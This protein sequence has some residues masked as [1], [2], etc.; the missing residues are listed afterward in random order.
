MPAVKR[1]KRHRRRTFLREWRNYRKMTLEQVAA[2]IGYDHSNLVRLETGKIPYNQDH[3]ELLAGVYRCEPTDLISRDPEGDPNG[4]EIARQF[5][6]APP[7]L[8]R[9]AAAV[10]GALLH[11]KR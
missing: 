9:Q 8:Q 10:L 1:P 3:L 7:D 6:A 2:L 4:A 5:A 11:P